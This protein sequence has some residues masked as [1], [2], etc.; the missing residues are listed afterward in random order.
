MGGEVHLCVAIVSGECLRV[1][2]VIAEDV[3]EDLNVLGL[4][5]RRCGILNRVE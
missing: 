4:G 3:V 1:A 2:V 5:R